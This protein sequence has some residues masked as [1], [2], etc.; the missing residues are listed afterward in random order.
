MGKKSHVGLAWHINKA[1]NACKPSVSAHLENF[2]ELEMTSRALK[3][4]RGLMVAKKS[5][6]LVPEPAYRRIECSYQSNLW[7]ATLPLEPEEEDTLHI[8]EEPDR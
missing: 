2:L 3:F 8:K 4:S 5:V 6:P 1:L 7:V